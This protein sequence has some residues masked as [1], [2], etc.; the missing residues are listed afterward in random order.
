[1]AADDLLTPHSRIRLQPLADGAL[2]VTY[3]PIGADAFPPDPPWLLD[4]LAGRDPGLPHAGGSVAATVKGGCLEIT[5]PDGR[6]ILAE[7]RPARLAPDV[8]MAFRL[9]AGEILYG[10]GE[11]FGAFARTRGRLTLNAFNAPSFLQRHRS[12]SAIPMFF[13]R[14]GY[15]LLLLNAHPTQWNIDSRR[16]ELSVRAHAGAADYLLII[17]ETPREILRTYT[18]LTGRP[19]L[20][21]RWAHGLWGTG[22]PQE[23]QERVVELA[24]EHARHR[25]P[26]EVIILDYHWEEAFHNFRWRRSLFP[27][28]DR[29]L[30]DLGEMGIRLGLI[31]T[32]FVNRQ[33]RPLEKRVLNWRLRNV[34][35]AE[36]AS[37]ERALPEYEDCARRG[38]LAHPNAWWWFGRGG[39][40]DFTNRQTL[41]WWAAKLGPLLRQGIS[42][43]KN[44]DGEYLPATGS[45]ALGLKGPEHHNLY[46]FYYGKATYEALQSVDDRRPI[47]YARSVWA[48]S[49]R[50]PGLFLGDQTPTFGHMRSTLRAGLNLGLAGF[51]YWTADVFGLDGRTTPET[52]MRYAQWALFA[53]I[54]RYFWRPARIDATRFPWSHGEAAEANFRRLTDL[55]RC[56]A[57][58]YAGLAWEAH[59]S[60][61]PLLRPMLLEYPHDPLFERTD[62]QLMIGADL[63]LAP[64]LEAGA[65]MRQVV[66]PPGAWH[67]FWTERTWDGVDSAMVAAPLDRVPLLVRGGAL[68]PM[69]PPGKPAPDGTGY[70]NLELHLWPP[71]GGAYNLR[72]DDGL[73]RAYQRGEAAETGLRVEQQGDQVDLHIASPNG[74][75]PG[76]PEERRWTIVLHRVAAV[77]RP[78]QEPEH[79][80]CEVALSGGTAS[81]RIRFPTR[82]GCVLHIPGVATGATRLA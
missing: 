48:G 65:Q 40:L 46:G 5:R 36:I 39:M 55:R 54:A 8:R 38:L 51:A 10:W 68:I 25:I 53:P 9:S 59:Q 29:L 79:G 61:I 44:D 78:Q 11:Q 32:P 58:Y 49:Q 76:L 7:A 18:G 26:L 19:P 82:L 20:L 50:Y 14:R 16:G 43:F 41:D 1:M 81:I 33:N 74:G 27:D 75:F 72:E 70:S 45:S 37:D 35:P 52:H 24:R 17:G 47:V 80:E 66:L 22:Y 31:L 28:P 30:R 6:L 63:L 23:D 64:V 21:P 67:D 69:T 2:R 77:G 56:L 3:A 60:G 13:S 42:F 62:D 34:P 15:A 4:L 57:P 73:T 71:F 12:Y